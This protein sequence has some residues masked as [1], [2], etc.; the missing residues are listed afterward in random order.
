MGRRVVVQLPF[1]MAGG[2]DS[3]VDH[4]DGAHRHVSVVGSPV[5]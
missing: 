4:H 3:T 5:A 1:V 2:H